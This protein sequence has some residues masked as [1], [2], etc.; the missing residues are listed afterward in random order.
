MEAFV[1]LHSGYNPQERALRRR[2]IY[3]CCAANRIKQNFLFPLI[4]CVLSKQS[5]SLE[6]FV[7]NTFLFLDE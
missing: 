5:L 7:E 3:L 1:E 2:H 4:F 6:C